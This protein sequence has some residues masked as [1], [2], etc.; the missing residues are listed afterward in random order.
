ML[1]CNDKVSVAILQKKKITSS[2]VLP[3]QT[4]SKVISFVLK[5]VGLQWNFGVLG[6]HSIE[7]GLENWDT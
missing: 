6:W 1:Q 5:N 3:C 4:E 7:Q 2:V